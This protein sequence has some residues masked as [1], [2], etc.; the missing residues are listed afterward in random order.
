MR[1]ML[2]SITVGPIQFD[3]PVWLW[4]IPVLWALTIWIGR[5]SLSGLGTTTRRVALVVRL[6]VIALLAGAMAEPQWRKVAKDV[7]VTVVLDAS[8]SIPQS[9]QTDLERY[10]EDARGANMKERPDDQLGVVTVAN[11]AYVQSLPSKLNAKVEKQ[12]VG[13]DLGTNLAGGVRLAM[14]VKKEDAANRLVLMSDGNETAGSLLDTAEAAKAMGLPIDVLAV[15]YSME[16]EV[17]M[18]Q[19]VAPGT[20]RMGETVNLKVVL[21]ATKPTKGTVHLLLNDDPVPL[22]SEQGKTGAD[23]TL[24]KGMNVFP[25]Q[26][27][28]QK[29]GPQRFKAVF[30]PEK[31][32]SGRAIGDTTPEN[33]EQLAVTFVTSEGKALVIAPNGPSGAEDVQPM[34][35]ALTQSK[36]ASEVI[37]PDQVPKSLTELN[38][39]DVIIMMDQAAYDYSQQ[40]QEE[41]RQY[42][43]DTGGGIVMTGGPSSFGAG[44]WIGSPLE[45]ALPIRLDPPQKRQMPRG[46][47][48]IVSHS[49]EMP[50]G[51]SWGKKTAQA[52]VDA[53]SRLDL[54][55]IVEFDY[56]KSGGVSW[57]HPLSE[58]GDG[59]AIRRSIQNLAFGDM[60]D[61]NSVLTKALEGLAGVEAGA[62]HVIMITDGDAQMPSNSLLQKY[63]K[64]R[65]TISTV[66]VYP[67]SGADLKKLQQ[68]AD[69]TGGKHYEVVNQGGLGQIVQIFIKEAQTVKRALI[70]EGDPFVPAM[71]GAPA[72]SMRGVTG[73]P[74]IGGYVVTGEREGLALVTL[75][76]K[77]NDPI[78]AQWQYGLGR[79]AAFTSDAAARWDPAWVGWPGY[80]A[81]WEQHVRWAMR[82]SG[83]PNIHVTTEKVGD[84]TRVIV[85]ALDAGGERLNFAR[86]KGRVA[87]PDGQGQDL[88]LQQVGPGRYEGRFDSKQA[89]TFVVSM[90]Y[91]APRTGGGTAPGG[92]APQD[93]GQSDVIEGSVQAAV[94][95]PFADEFR[96]LTDNEPL[97]QRV[98]AMTGG[99]MLTGD[100]AKDDL[101]R[102]EGLTMP[103]A[104]TPIWLAFAISG[105]GLFLLDVGVRRVRIDIPG[106]ARAVRRS[107]ETRKEKH[108]QQMGALQ[109][110][111]EQARKVMAERSVT[112]GASG[113]VAAHAAPV[114]SASAKVKFE[115]SADRVKKQGA[116]P[117]AVGGPVEEKKGAGE[118]AEKAVSKEEGLSR[119]MQA[120]KRA[121]EGMEEE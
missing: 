98:A 115:A 96:A 24:T 14:A 28:V 26:V 95:R 12:F 83:S 21:S 119:L 2:G 105:I 43:H 72:E 118:K 45:D 57:V 40:S 102:R 94:T 51:V 17:M 100:P 10:V 8:R 50:D 58:I 116:G 71:T 79:V 36:I 54:A 111:R 88:D 32:A 27:T 22:T 64:E 93:S 48:V 53:L 114:A 37:T 117:V 35:A 41:L 91:V 56:R 78:A 101:W 76:G 55:G 90:R 29:A 77:E 25:V 70:W 110:A 5:T 69:T 7:A 81:F 92:A 103:V 42:V 75:R 49:I 44:G 60:P 68:I 63:K 34:V 73:V 109:K 3:T 1:M 107:M 9:W 16:S 13:G 108:G 38:G 52:A 106:M 84:Q 59:S 80:K 46:A 15:R 121:R 23:V 113:G 19:L 112:P 67:H 89:G 20:A 85:D 74:P 4:L 62:K 87:G 47:L 82:P 104:I 30:E 99:K 11:D 66:G 61:Y 33:N 31:D 120:K 65:V 86:F 97:L 18:E 39:Y 6:L